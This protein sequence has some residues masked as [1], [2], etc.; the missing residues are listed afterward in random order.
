[1]PNFRGLC[2]VILLFLSGAN[3]GLSQGIRRIPRKPPELPQFNLS[4]TLDRLEVNYIELTT[5]AGYTW[6][7]QPMKKVQI[8]LT[9]KATPAFLA[10][11]QCVAFLARLDMRRGATVEQVRRLTVFTPDKRRQFG[12][13]PDLGFA[14]LE[15]ETFEKRPNSQG[16]AIS[17]NKPS[18]ARSGSSSAG[19][20]APD[21]IRGRRTPVKVLPENIETFIVHG[22]I[23]SMEKGDL[24]VQVPNNVYVKSNLKIAVAE[25]ADIDVELAGVPALTLVR[26]G[27]H[28]QARGD[29]IGEGL[30]FVNNLTFRVVQP[31]GKP[32]DTKKPPSK[33]KT[34]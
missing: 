28:V 27:D 30:G 8:R 11:G 16:A 25:D 14:D 32:L 21:G 34:R 4:G 17:E 23:V 15:K 22:R 12:I 18:A 19:S 20:S 33:T 2:L 1:M 10:P 29:Q 6:I 7:L 5:E 13:Q 24:F 26:P 3:L 9:G 31:L